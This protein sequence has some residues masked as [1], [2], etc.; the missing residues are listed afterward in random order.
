MCVC[1]FLYVFNCGRASQW[2]RYINTALNVPV[3]VCRLGCPP[4]NCLGLGCRGVTTN[5]PVV[6]VSGLSQRLA[7]SWC[8]RLGLGFRV[9]LKPTNTNPK[10]LKR[11]SHDKPQIQKQ[12]T[13]NPK[14]CA[15]KTCYSETYLREAA[16]DD[17]TQTTQQLKSELEACIKVCLSFPFKHSN[18]DSE[19]QKP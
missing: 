11:K 17:A 12:T 7:W 18:R 16:A 10:H 1:L 9:A 2:A 8:W 19:A 3:L 5:S 15:H 14:P 6:N 4:D 13:C